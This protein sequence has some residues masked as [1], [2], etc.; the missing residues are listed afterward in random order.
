MVET[1]YDLNCY[2][3]PA[4]KSLKMHRTFYGLWRRS[5]DKATVWLQRV[6]SCIRHCAYPTIT[7]EFLAFDRFICGLTANELKSIQSVRSSWSL[8]QL[9]EHF[10]NTNFEPKP[11][12]TGKPKNSAIDSNTNQ[13]DNITLDVTKS[14]PVRYQALERH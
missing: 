5:D 1:I 12:R 11:G 9:M 4:D 13:T 3:I 10:S 8:N 6:Q 2:E 14:E 7:M